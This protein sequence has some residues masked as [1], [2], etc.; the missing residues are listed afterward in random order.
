MG[1]VGGQPPSL[2]TGKQ[3]RGWW[4]APLWLRVE[5]TLTFLRLN[6]KCP[7]PGESRVGTR[8]RNPE[9]RPLLDGPDLGHEKGSHSIEY[10]GNSRLTPGSF[11]KPSPPN[12]LSHPKATLWCPRA[13]QPLELWLPPLQASSPSSVLYVAFLPL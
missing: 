11:L 13:S 8:G 6:S 2:V 7:P 10:L 4:R 5:G 9:L 1:G 12:P 3:D